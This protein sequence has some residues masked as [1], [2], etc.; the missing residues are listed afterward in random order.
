MLEDAWLWRRSDLREARVAERSERQRHRSEKET[1][2]SH[3][4]EHA[5]FRSRVRERLANASG[6]G[7]PYGKMP[8]GAASIRHLRWQPWRH[9]TYLTGRSGE[10]RLMFII[11]KTGLNQ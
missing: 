8:A 7:N 4:R 9:S 2:K 5:A 6:H 1:L 3:M 11:L 10:R